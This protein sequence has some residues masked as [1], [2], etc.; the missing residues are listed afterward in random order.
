MPSR[1]NTAHRK[2]RNYRWE[3]VEEL[4]YKEDARALFKSITRQVLFSDPA[5][6]GDAP[7]R[8]CPRRILR[9]SGT[10]TCTPCSCCAVEVT[11][12]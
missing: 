7:F 10:S 5:M 4:P 9:W 11:A 3:G 12:S 1:E 8:G 2:E 6:Q